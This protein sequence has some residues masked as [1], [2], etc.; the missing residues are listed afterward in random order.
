[1]TSHTCKIRD[2]TAFQRDLLF[3]L[4]GLDDPKGLDIKDE[5]ECRYGQFRPPRLYK[6]LDTLVEKGLIEKER[7]DYRTNTYSLTEHG[8]KEVQD[9]LAWEIDHLQPA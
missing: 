5:M 7:C 1:M 9:R 6:N 4:T 2:L 8:R 3:V